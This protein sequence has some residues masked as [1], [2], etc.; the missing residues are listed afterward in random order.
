M[1]E[2]VEGK[3]GFKQVRA[4]DYLWSQSWKSCDNDIEGFDLS[5]RIM[6]SYL[7]PL[8][9]GGVNT[10]AAEKGRMEKRRVA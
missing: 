6:G 1:R 5:C 2:H 4:T 7:K 8:T 10:L 9:D 3:S